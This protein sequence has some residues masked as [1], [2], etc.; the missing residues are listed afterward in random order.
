MSQSRKGSATEAVINMAVGL[1]VSFAVNTVV[2][3]LFGWHISGTANV[4][5]VAIYTA[6]SIIRSYCLRRLFNAIGSRKA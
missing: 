6:V 5:L 4:E 3:P 1:C 2:Y